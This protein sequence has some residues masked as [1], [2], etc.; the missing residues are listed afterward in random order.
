MKILLE[1]YKVVDQPLFSLASV[2]VS[3]DVACLFEESILKQCR[4]IMLI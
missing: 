1:K 3:P 2:D 4:W